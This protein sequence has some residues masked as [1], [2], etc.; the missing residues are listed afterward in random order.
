MSPSTLGAPNVIGP[1]EELMNGARWIKTSPW[2]GLDDLASISDE[3]LVQ[4]LRQ[5]KERLLSCIRPLMRSAR[6]V[7]LYCAAQT[8]RSSFSIPDRKKPVLSAGSR[9]GICR[10]F[11]MQWENYAAAR[12]YRCPSSS[13]YRL[14][15]PGH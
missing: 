2:A 10:P 11:Q 8:S 15:K 7:P 4:I 6:S 12:A 3:R 14:D 9:V 13:L 1:D 5:S